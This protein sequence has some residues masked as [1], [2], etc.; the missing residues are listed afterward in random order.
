MSIFAAASFDDLAFEREM[1][2]LDRELQEAAAS[3]T[4]SP[5]AVDPSTELKSFTFDKGEFMSLRGFDKRDTIVAPA[6]IAA[7]TVGTGDDE[8]TMHIDRPVDELIENVYSNGKAKLMLFTPDS[9]ISMHLEHPSRLMWNNKQPASEELTF[10]FPQD[11]E[12]PV[13]SRERKPL[14]IFSTRKDRI[15]MDEVLAN[16]RPP[17]GSPPASPETVATIERAPPSTTSTAR[18]RPP[19]SGVNAQPNLVKRKAIS[20]PAPPMEAQITPQANNVSASDQPVQ[21]PKAARKKTSST[22]KRRKGIS[23]GKL[24][25]TKGCGLVCKSTGDLARHLQ[26][27]MHQTPSVPCPKGCGKLFSRKDGANRHNRKN[28]CAKAPRR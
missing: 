13:T 2:V 16:Y 9:S 5:M 18:L 25:C 7:A 3:I 21:R 14:H 26:S 19:R 6:Y 8:H 17:L 11:V 23:S 1:K 12:P 28:T 20:N 22:S 27:T 24:P 10:V 15:R 4:D